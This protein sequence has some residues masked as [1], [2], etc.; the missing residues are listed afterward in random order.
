[1]KYLVIFIVIY[2]FFYTAT[3][4]FKLSVDLMTDMLFLVLASSVASAFFIT[5]KKRFPS[6]KEQKILLWG[7]I[8][9]AWIT[10]IL[11]NLI[12]V[13]D[14]PFIKMY[15]V[16]FPEHI[17]IAIVFVWIILIVVFVI[18]ILFEYL[19]LKWTF[20]LLG[21]QY[22][23]IMSKVIDNSESMQS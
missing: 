21:K 12:F 3:D 4:Y 11:Y 16:L 20:K 2:N 18:F 22:N 10:S 13:G 15:Q 7:Y 17:S 14:K 8:L 1:M 5:D 23:K 19:I 6:E 9:A